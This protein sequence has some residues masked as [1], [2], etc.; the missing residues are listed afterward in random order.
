MRFAG[1]SPQIASYMQSS[2]RFDEMGDMYGKART[3]ERN[4]GHEAEAIVAGSGLDAMGQVKAASHQ[5]RGIEAQ[6]AAQAAAT[7]ARGFQGMFSGIA[8]GIGNMSFGGGS[9][10]PGIGTGANF[11]EVG[12]SGSDMADFSY[13]PAQDAAFNSGAGIDYGYL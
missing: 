6:G 1:S 3:H 8:S 12:T 13:T 5:A 7:E 9:G 10:S 4:T 11:G 2:P